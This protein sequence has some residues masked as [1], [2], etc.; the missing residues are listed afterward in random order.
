MLICHRQIS[1]RFTLWI[2]TFVPDLS[3]A[4]SSQV[5]RHSIRY[6]ESQ[7]PFRLSDGI[8]A[9]PDSIPGIKDN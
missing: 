4:R 7:I 8:F 5:T 2:K 6:E 9:L 1:F 3:D